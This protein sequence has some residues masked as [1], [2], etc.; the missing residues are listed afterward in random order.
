[1]PDDGAAKEAVAGVM[2]AVR[3]GVDN[4][5][6]LTVSGDFIPPVYGVGRHLRRVNKH[7]SFAGDNEGMIAPAY[8]SFGVNVAGDLLYHLFLLTIF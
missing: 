6:Y 1:V 2:V 3:L 7:D 8:S 4:I 5:L